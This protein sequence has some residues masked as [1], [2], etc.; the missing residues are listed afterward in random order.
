MPIKAS[1]QAETPVYEPFGGGLTWIAHPDEAMGRASHALATDAGV[2]LLDPVDAAGLDDQ[3]A[4]YGDVAGVAILVERH[5]RDAVTVANRHEVPVTRPPGIDRSVE[6]PTRDVTDGLPGTDYEFLTVQ[7]GPLWQEIALWDGST[8]IVPESFGTNDFSCVGDERLGL[9]PVA[10]LL[11][12]R[13]LRAYDPERLL[14]GH[15]APLFDDVT[16]SIRTALGNARRRLPKAWLK[17]AK[18]FL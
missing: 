17:M 8:M 18:A 10:R 15:G 13:H 5:E 6:A 1:G 7:D 14:V 2:W 3:L 16:P 9:N 11:P 12:P 4:A